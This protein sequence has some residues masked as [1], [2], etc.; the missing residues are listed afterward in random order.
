MAPFITSTVGLFH[1]QLD[2]S[3]L[4]SNYFIQFLHFKF[5]PSVHL[6]NIQFRFKSSF[7][8]NRQF[9]YSILDNH[10]ILALI[11]NPNLYIQSLIYTFNRQFPKSSNIV[12]N[13]TGNERVILMSRPACFGGKTKHDLFLRCK[14][15]EI[16]YPRNKNLAS[17]ISIVSG[18]DIGTP[19]FL[20][21]HLPL[22]NRGNKLRIEL[23]LP[24]LLYRW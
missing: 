22:I 19:S 13:L 24:H 16:S 4:F 15:L 21:K 9:L 5:N 2:T 14:I 12:L 11:F 6:F 8:L 10:S 7:I 23:A 20:A 18:V 1:F 3:S 17:P